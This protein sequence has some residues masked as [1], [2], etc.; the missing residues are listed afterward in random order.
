MIKI[1]NI[2][3]AW[4][5]NGSEKIVFDGFSLQVSK[6]DFVAII[7]KNGTGK[8][9]LFNIVAALDKNYSGEVTVNDSKKYRVGYVFQNY[10]QS[11]FPWLNVFQNIAYPLRL[12]G[13]NNE[14]CQKIIDKLCQ[15]FNIKV[16]FKKYPYELSGGQQQIVST[17]RALV[18]K[19]DIL[20]LD[21]PFS[22][23]DYDSTLSLINLLQ[24]VWLKTGVTVLLISHDIDEAIILAKKIYVLQ[25][26][27]N[28]KIK[29]DF[30]NPEIYPRN[31]LIMGKPETIKLKEMILQTFISTTNNKNY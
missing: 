21:E 3:K 20:L 25:E 12:E 5:N 10:R 29:K 28:N 31:V 19:P 17:L 15:E 22:A 4:G 6:G 2:K 27:P 13:K 18:F 1:D 16:D 9:T 11:L 7:G 24:Q 26:D 8:T 23:V 14:E 30:V